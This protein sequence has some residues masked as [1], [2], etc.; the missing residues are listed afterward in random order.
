MAFNQCF[1]HLIEGLLIGVQV[2]NDALMPSAELIATFQ[3]TIEGYV[4]CPVRTARLEILLDGLALVRASQ[5]VSKLR[6]LP[7]LKIGFKVSIGSQT[8]SIR[9][10]RS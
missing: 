1:E 5:R 10:D 8:A 3:T 2:V 7:Q 6:D 9:Q 4:V